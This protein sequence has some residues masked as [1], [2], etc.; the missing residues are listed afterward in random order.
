MMDI[1]AF[2]L[3]MQSQA[4][5]IMTE[6]RDSLSYHSPMLDLSF[7]QLLQEQINQAS[8][9][10]NPMGQ[11]A[12]YENTYAPPIYHAN[13]GVNSSAN[14]PATQFNSIIT[15]TAQKYGID[16]KLI[17]AVIKNE[18]NY[19]PM[20]KSHA[21]AQGLMQLMPGT[22]RGL[23]VT[24]SYD[25]RQ[26][27]EGGTK[28]LSQMLKKYNGNLELSLAAYNAGPGNVDKYQ[29]IPPFNETQNYVKKVLNNYLA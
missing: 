27:I 10:G 7:K 5:S 4:A 23:G 14:I 28:Y 13:T 9:L 2:Q 24:N 18:S 19:N 3:M 11:T 8:A 22:A 6:N 21:G 1:K 17:H 29:G 16:E 12:S 15:E 20:A 25:A 26:N